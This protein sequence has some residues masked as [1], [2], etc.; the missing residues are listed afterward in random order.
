MAPSL[1]GCMIVGFYNEK[2]EDF[3]EHNRVINISNGKWEM[4]DTTI[5][6][7]F[8]D[9]NAKIWFQ[10]FL[11]DDKDEREYLVT[12][13]Y[14]WTGVY[15]ESERILS[16]GNNHSM[17]LAEKGLKA[18][19]TKDE[20]GNPEFFIINEALIS[21]L[22]ILGE[23]AEPCF[24]G[25]Q[26]GMS[27]SLDDNF[28]DKLFTMISD[29]QKLIKEG[30]T[31]VITT[32]S[33]KVGEPLW[34]SLYDHI[35][36]N[37][38]PE[39]DI[40]GIYEEENQKFAVIHDIAE[41][42]YYSLN[43]SIDDK[44]NFVADEDM[45]EY[46]DYTP[47]ETPQ[48]DPAEVAE[49]ISKRDKEE[50]KIKN[51]PEGTDPK[52]DLDNA[53]NK[54]EGGPKIGEN[55]GEDP[56]EE[57]RKKRKKASFAKE[58]SNDD[59]RASGEKEKICPK[60]GKPLSEC[61]CDDNEDPKE[62]KSPKEK[63]FSITEMPEYIELCKK[64]IKLQADYEELNKNYE[65]LNSEVEPL[66]QFKATTELK[67]KEE[68]IDRFYMLSNEDKKDVID[69]INTYS[70]DDI[71]AKLSVLCVHKKVSFD[72]D[73]NPN[74][75]TTFSLNNG[76]AGADFSDAPAWVQAAINVAKQMN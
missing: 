11:D 22:C 41:G 25:S 21:K 73:F 36:D 7:G 75:T 76:G 1:R 28:K 57:R 19:W 23:D 64:F 3:E 58:E 46:V 74:G 48:F 30:G 27:F 67:A 40:C 9:I 35:A 20:N 6:Y 62:D 56:M 43:F 60:C 24:E 51:E 10:K 59:K 71:E 5:P 63:K 2:I 50:K 49:Y 8:V 42:K 38:E 68:M 44:G 33:V 72:D 18:N 55:H 37:Y 14:I 29:V 47:S 17:E 16:K 53:N 26:I 54:A 12:E 45:I 32:Y 66:R 4:K 13:G 69:N 61:T 15:P 70:L 65:T 31:E 52:L 39:F 34:V